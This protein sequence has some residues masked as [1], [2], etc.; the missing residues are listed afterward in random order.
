M[1]RTIPNEINFL[2]VVCVSFQIHY[3]HLSM[4]T[5]PT[6]FDF[7][8][9]EL[10]ATVDQALQ[11]ARASLK[12]LLQLSKNKLSFQNTFVA[13]ETLRADLLEETNFI[14]F[15]KS[16]STDKATRDMAQKLEVK[17][18]AFFT[19]LYLNTALYQRLKQ[20]KPKHLSLQEKTLHQKTLLDF[21]RSGTH[22]PPFKRKKMMQIEKTI[23]KLQSQYEMNI[24]S[25]QDHIDVTAADLKNFPQTYIDQLAKTQNGYRVNLDYPQFLPFIKLC[26]NENLRKEIELKSSLK[27]GTKNLKLFQKTLLLRAQLAK[28]LGYKTYAA[29]VLSDRMART[30]KTVQTFLKALQKKLRPKLEAEISALIKLKQKDDKTATTLY[31]WDW[32]YYVNLLKEQNFSFSEEETRE[33]FPLSKVFEGMFHIFQTLFEISIQKIKPQA[34]WH[35]DVELFEIKDKKTLKT[36][37]FFYMDLFPREGKYKH[38][39]A[40]TLRSGRNNPHADTYTPPI[41]A[42]VANFQP[43]SQNTPSLLSHG[44]VETLFH[45]FGHILH[46]VM[47]KAQFARFS[48]TSVLRDFVETPSQLFEHW[49]YEETIL[50]LISEHFKTK[51]PFPK[52]LL[53][54][55]VSAKAVDLGLHYSRQLFFGLIDM[56]Y[57]T[58]SKVPDL[59]KLWR[60][61]QDEVFM[62][63]SH[64]KSLSVA[65]FGH[66]MGGYQAGYYGYLWSEVYAFDVFS[67]FKKEG[68]QSPKVGKDYR[69]WVLETGGSRPPMELL[70]GFLG[71][72]PNPEAFYQELGIQ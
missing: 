65:G 55:M 70:K 59:M 53:K 29:F 23:S 33:Y 30:P 63:P 21:K 64:P 28:L 57:H 1:R 47:T 66:L 12:N 25:H 54:N 20:V 24:A 42:I 19:E 7:S 2:Q 67:R 68:L 10:Q 13:F 44:E 18:D 37:A 58:R 6:R 36:L 49:T 43:P 8:P 5:L 71:R 14:L 62:I 11:K 46:Q 39:A 31:S 50:P 72:T 16:V 52:S 35:K 60:H 32:R 61:V 27:G 69:Q 3:K 4:N 56:E 38:A 41:S 15:L 51:A 40:F 34:L 45:E 9:K 26:K 22:L 17:I 48:G